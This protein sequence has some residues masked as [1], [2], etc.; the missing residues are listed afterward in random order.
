MDPPHAIQ[1]GELIIQYPRLKHEPICVDIVVP[2][3][4]NLTNRTRTEHSLNHGRDF[5]GFEAFT[6]MVSLSQ[7]VRACLIL[8]QGPK[9]PKVN[10]KAEKTLRQCT[11][12]MPVYAGKNHF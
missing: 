10:T 11:P 12:I 1:A 9:N 3:R 4:G 6:A 2:L 8:R 5:S 7:P